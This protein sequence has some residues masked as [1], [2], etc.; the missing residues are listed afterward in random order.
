LSGCLQTIGDGPVVGDCADYPEGTYTY[1]QIGIGTC[2]SGPADLTFIDGDEG[3]MLVVTNADPYVNFRGGSTLVIDFDSIDMTK[4]RN[5][6]NEIAAYSHEM[7]RYL[8]GVAHLADRDLLLVAGRMSPDTLTRDHDDRVHVLDISD[9]TNPTPW[10]YGDEITVKDDPFPVV[11]SEDQTRAFVVNLS[12][13]SV[14]VIDTETGPLEVVDIVGAAELGEGLFTDADSS[15]SF[16]ELD[17]PFEINAA[18]IVSDQW[19]LSWLDGTYRLWIPRENGLERWSTGDGNNYHQSALGLELDPT[20]ASSIEEVADPHLAWV[21]GELTNYFSDRGIIRYATSIGTAGDWELSS[22]IVLAGNEETSFLAGPSVTTLDERIAL[23]YDARA[24]EE[25]A[26]HIG[27]SIIGD[28]SI[29]PFTDNRVLT[30][31]SEVESYEDPFVINEHGLLRMWFSHWDGL[32]WSISY[33]EGYDGSTWT[34]P[35]QQIRLTDGHVA[36]PVISYANGRYQLWC[37]LSEDGQSWSHATA[38]SYNGRNWNDLNPQLSANDAFTISEPP[39]TGVQVETTSAWNI[40]ARDLGPMSA[41]AAAGDMTTSGGFSFTVASGHAVPTNALV[42]DGSLNGMEPG[43]YAEINGVPTLFVTGTSSNTFTQIAALQ[44]VSGEWVDL[45]EQVIAHANASH[46]VVVPTAN[47]W[48]MYYSAPTDDGRTRIQ[49]ALSDNGINFTPESTDLIFTGESWDDLGQYPHSAQLLDNGTLALWYAGDNGSRLRIGAAITTDGL[50]FEPKEGVSQDYIFGPGEPGT[51]DDSGVKNPFIFTN[52]D[53]TAMYYAGFDGNI[54]SLGYAEQSAGGW[55]RRTNP[56]TGEGI[57]SMSGVSGSFSVGGVQSPVVTGI[58]DEIQVYYAGF[59]TFKHR[60][61]YAEGGEVLFPI[62]SFPTVGDTL[63][64]E[65]TRGDDESS[66]IELAQNLDTFATD[67]TGTSGLILDESRGF[68]YI[69]S[70]LRSHVYVIDVRDDSSGDYVDANYLDIEALIQVPS[71]AGSMGFRSALLLEQRDQLLLTSREPDGVVIIDLTSLE[72]NNIK[73]SIDG[74]AI[75][76]L[77]LRDLRQNEGDITLA[78]IGGA[79]MAVSSDERI[80]LVTNFRGNAVSVFDLELGL[81][82]E[83]IKYIRDLGENPHIVQFSPDE[84][85]AVV[86]NYVG[87]V[88]DN[89]VSSTLAIID[90]DES[91]EHYLEVV[92]WLVNQ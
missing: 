78:S 46:P 45:G 21:S 26:A 23:F 84:K 66:V 83:E 32:N 61:G 10:I 82:G 69:P 74:A 3:N 59:D 33:S 55:K 19:T 79:G 39:R 15:G 54:W 11:V 38:W 70:K 76:V 40:I 60:I 31:V 68:L 91:S 7:D 29:F 52:G 4:R 28:D 63:I 49:S 53:T 36:A 87:N 41:D 27:L 57:P 6:M 20:F 1:G 77:P 42:D 25:D 30:P 50:N 85:Y 34:D 65:T 22:T 92:T 9:P 8:G 90:M 2:L 14:S 47:G 51:F 67:G 81:F 16:A 80:L 62:Q 17:G 71:T 72:D 18:D 44:L 89:K 43:S 88:V 64:F 37:T 73:E 13:H 86:G 48:R 12:D 24:T 75:G 5:F 56:F 58:G 35:Q